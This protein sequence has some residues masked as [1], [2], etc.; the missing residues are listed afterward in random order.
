MSSLG[1]GSVAWAPHIGTRCWPHYAGLCP[2]GIQSGE[3]N[4]QSR[5][6]WASEPQEPGTI[7]VLSSDALSIASWSC[8]HQGCPTSWGISHQPS[9]ILCPDC[10]VRSHCTLG[11]S[12]SA[13]LRP[14]RLHAVGAA[15]VFLECLD[16]TP[17]DRTPGASTLGRAP[18][19]H[20]V[21][22]FSPELGVPRPPGR[23]LSRPPR[24][25]FLPPPRPF[26]IPVP[27]GQPRARRS[28]PAAYRLLLRA[29]PSASQG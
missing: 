11:A 16:R 24:S 2:C 12:V 14:Q 4:S 29:P 26:H 15:K 6:G 3:T 28:Q 7:S 25:H 5:P 21:P 10:S 27:P 19:P 17:G 20:L 18:H 23:L 13:T 1:Q 22:G 9:W 8:E